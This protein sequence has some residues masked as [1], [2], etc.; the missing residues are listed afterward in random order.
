MKRPFAGWFTI[1]LLAIS[2]FSLCAYAVIAAENKSIVVDFAS[3]TVEGVKIRGEIADIKRAIGSSRI[4]ETTEEREGQPSEM[5]ILSFGTHKVYK[6]WN[7]FSYKDPIFRT[8]EG[9]G[10]GS[11]VKDF[12]RMYGTGR[13]SQEEGFAIYYKTKT[14]QIALT[15]KFVDSREQDIDLYTNS[16]VDE[17]YVW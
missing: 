4:E 12:N 17:I 8:K 10:V 1:V 3:G 7:A 2:S 6:H 9:L 5:Y 14:V 16:I 13:V 15:T 11:K